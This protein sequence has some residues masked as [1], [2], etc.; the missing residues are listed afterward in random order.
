MI[1]TIIPTLKQYEAWKAFWDKDIIYILFGG[2][3]GGGKSWCGAEWLMTSCYQYP[4]TRWFIGRKELSRLMKSSFITF[5]KV[6]HFHKIPRDDWKLNGQYNYIEFKNGSRI[7]LL[8]LDYKPSDADYERFGS[9]EYTGGWIEEAGEVDFGAF[10][11]L[12]TRV[13]RHLNKE[14]NLPPKIFIT[15]NPSKNWLYRI[16]YKLYKKGTLPKE[17]IFIPSLYGD[18]PHTAETYGKM[19]GQITDKIKKQRLK[20]GQWEYDE[21]QNKLMDFDAITDLFTNAIDKDDQKY[22]TA[23]IARYGQDK[24]IIM[25]WKGF[26]VYKILEYTKQGIDVTTDKIR[27]LL[28]T[29][30]IPYSH[31]IADEDGVGGGVID[32][33]RGIKGFVANSSPLNNPQSNKTENYRNLKAQCSYMLTEKINNRE[34]AIKAEVSEK[35]KEHII[36]ELDQIRSKDIEKDTKLQ[37]APKEEVKEMIGRSPD[38]ADAIVQR[39]YFLLDRTGN[40]H[41]PFKQPKYKSISAYEGS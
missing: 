30:Q 36:E 4:N 32:S 29:E 3:A 39:M 12:K 1:P 20:F 25:L 9:L 11:I 22:L 28:R 18:N 23:D 37:I 21:N 16:I 2:G 13:G 27:D 35:Q 34:L 33:L 17:Y 15:C 31:T 40:V 7:D 14:Y 6:C 10:D 24:T 38:Y 8:D 19:L 41:K 5:Q 26:E